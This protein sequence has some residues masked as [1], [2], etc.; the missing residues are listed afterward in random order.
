MRF[1]PAANLTGLPAIS[2]PAGYDD[3]GLPVGFQ[4]MGRPW[5][6]APLLRLAL[7][8]ERVARAL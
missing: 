8:H 7:A 6:E 5:E 1:V 3:D 4:A 2:F